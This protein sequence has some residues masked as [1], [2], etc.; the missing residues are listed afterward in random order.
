MRRAGMVVESVKGECNFGQHEVAFQVRHAGRQVRRARSVQAR[1]EGDRGPRGRAA[2]P[3]WP[4]TTSA[5]ETPVTFTSRC[6]TRRQ[7]AGLRGRSEHG[8]SKVFEHFLAGQARLLARTLTLARAQHQQLQAIRRRIVRPDRA[9]L[10]TRQPHLLFRVVGHGP[11]IRVECRIPGG[12]VNPY[13]AIAALVAAGLRGI[14][15]SLPLAPPSKATP[16]RP[17][18]PRVP[19]TLAKRPSCLTERRRAR[20]LRRRRRRSL[21]ARRARI[22]VDAFDAAVTDWERYR[23]FER[24]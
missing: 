20:R 17:T 24:L 6:A 8:F 1:R 16:T 21:R 4:S 12:D 23:G 11:S 2:S 7:P 5:R 10:G 22:E 9:A 3:S 18:R 19:T 15:E 14:E 13:L